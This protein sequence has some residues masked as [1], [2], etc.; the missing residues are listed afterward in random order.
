MPSMLQRN[1]TTTTGGTQNGSSVG[2]CT[3]CIGGVFFFFAR[4]APRFA[5][6]VGA[7]RQKFPHRKLSQKFVKSALLVGTGRGGGGGGG[8]VCLTESLPPS[9]LALSSSPP[10]CTRKEVGSA[11]GGG[12]L[13]LPPAKRN[14]F[15]LYRI[16]PL[17]FSPKFK[18]FC[19]NKNRRLCYLSAILRHLQQ[20][21]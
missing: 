1:P 14:Q 19:F 16:F 7:C 17:F 8:G 21:N 15:P 5:P 6:T 20:L 12:D 2:I 10:I 9:L 3:R 13:L 18:S 4:L 11:G